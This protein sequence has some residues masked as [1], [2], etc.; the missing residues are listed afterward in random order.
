[1]TGTLLYQQFAAAD[2]VDASEARF[3]TAAVREAVRSAQREGR[4]DAR[5]HRYRVRAW[6]ESL[7]SRLIT[8]TWSVSRDGVPVVGDTEI[9]EARHTAGG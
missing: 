1:M 2:A 4:Y 7:G 8:V 3:L 6:R 9:L 5:F